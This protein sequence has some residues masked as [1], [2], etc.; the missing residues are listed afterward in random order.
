[1]GQWL[2]RLTDNNRNWGFGLCFLYLRNLRCFKWNHKRVYR[3]YRALE[4]NLYAIE[5]RKRLVRD[6]PEPLAVPASRAVVWSVDLMHEQL[7][8]AQCH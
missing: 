4:L 6:K 2:L 5:Q 8:A 1:M 3:I 7:Q